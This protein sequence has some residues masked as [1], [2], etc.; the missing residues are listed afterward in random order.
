MPLAVATSKPETSPDNNIE[1]AYNILS[2]EESTP[3]VYY[4]NTKVTNGHRR[5][6]YYL[7]QLSTR[8]NNDCCKNLLLNEIIVAD[9]NVTIP[10]GVRATTYINLIYDIQHPKGSRGCQENTIVVDNVKSTLVTAP[11]AVAASKPETSPDNNIENAYNILS[12][13]ESTPDVITSTTKGMLIDIQT[14]IVKT[15]AYNNRSA[16]KLSMY[17]FRYFLLEV[18]L[19]LTV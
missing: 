6:A 1:N 16:L 13:E 19:I 5:K 2:T 14:A 12:T 15:C 7:K 4:I 18:V 17:L 3:D 9:P 8:D 10:N 11:L